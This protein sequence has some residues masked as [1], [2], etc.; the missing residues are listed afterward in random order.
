MTIQFTKTSATSHELTING[1]FKGW[2]TKLTRR[3]TGLQSQRVATFCCF[4]NG[5]EVKADS[6]TSLRGKI[7]KVLA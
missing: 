2:V 6:L 5:T 7:E 3:T 4:I 1:E